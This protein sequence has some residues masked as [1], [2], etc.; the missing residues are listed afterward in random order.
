MTLAIAAALPQDGSLVAMEYNEKIATFGEQGCSK[1][2]ALC[3]W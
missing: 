1:T 2:S 3:V